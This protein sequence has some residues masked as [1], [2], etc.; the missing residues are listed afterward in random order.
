MALTKKAR[1]PRSEPPRR[2]KPR[3]RIRPFPIVIALLVIAVGATAAWLQ[4]S[5]DPNAEPAATDAPASPQTAAVNTTPSPAPPEPPEPSVA[6]EEPVS[7][8]VT[9]TMSASAEADTVDY[10]GDKPEEKLSPVDDRQITETAADASTP[11][12]NGNS[13]ASSGATVAP[14]TDSPVAT[15]AAVVETSDVPPATPPLAVTTPETAVVPEA[16]VST[17]AAPQNPQEQ[18]QQT[19]QLTQPATVLAPAAQPQPSAPSRPAVALILTNLGLSPAQTQV[20]IENLPP[21]VTLAFAPYGRNLQKWTEEARAAGHEV[22]LEVPMEPIR[23]PENDPGP[24][25]LLTS[26][27]PGENAK[28]LNWLMDRFTGYI[29]VISFM[30]SRF[31]ASADHLRPMFNLLRDRNLLFIDARSSSKSVAYEVAL[32]MG[33]AA[34]SNDRYLDVEA[35]HPAIQRRLE[36]LLNIARQTG[37]AVGI[38]YPYPTTLELITHWSQT[39]VDKNV[40][41]VPISAITN[42]TRSDG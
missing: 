17:E 29:G 28:R 15:Q 30:G 2:T 4:L 11:G 23:F 31:T 38:G 42:S 24:H 26:L 3:R 13:I 14:Q 9:G 6:A 40:D 8:P 36:E 33:L 10:N 39:L 34:A 37:Q 12:E 21:Q 35:S 41:L 16:D 7:S 1:S 5:Y 22:L 27:S 25:A 19:A 32:D 18:P 20:A